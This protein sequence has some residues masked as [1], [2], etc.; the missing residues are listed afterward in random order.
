MCSIAA[1]V[2]FLIKRINFHVWLMLSYRRPYR[3]PKEVLL[4]EVYVPRTV[5]WGVYPAGYAIVIIFFL[6]IILLIAV[7]GLI[8]LRFNRGLSAGRI[9]DGMLVITMPTDEY[10]EKNSGILDI[11]EKHVPKGRIDGITV[12][13]DES[14]ISYSFLKMKKDTFSE[15]QNCLQ[16][17]TNKAKLN[18]F[19]NRSGQI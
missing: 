8:V 14:T 15:L 4:E 3:F 18:L 9:D 12:K 7:V 2:A 13:D 11:I 5:R 1:V 19:Y 6:G 17:I 10:K 16:E